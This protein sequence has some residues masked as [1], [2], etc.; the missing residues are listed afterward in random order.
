VAF[1]DTCA[2]ASVVVF[3]SISIFIRFYALIK[4]RGIF[5]STLSFNISESGVVSLC[6]VK[7]CVGVLLFIL[8]DKELFRTL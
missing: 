3:V 8:V 5:T 7:T 1:S 6:L 4:S 2:C